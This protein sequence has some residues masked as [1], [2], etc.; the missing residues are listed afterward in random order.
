MINLIK[1][2]TLIKSF[3]TLLYTLIFIQQTDEKNF[4]KLF[5]TLGFV[6]ILLSI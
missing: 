4:K 3:K 5:I 1:I 6:I 2:I